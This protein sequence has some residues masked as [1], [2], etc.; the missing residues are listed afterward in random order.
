MSYTVRFCN[1]NDQWTRYFVVCVDKTWGSPGCQPWTGD[2]VYAGAAPRGECIASPSFTPTRVLMAITSSDGGYYY[3][4]EFVD[5]QGRVVRRCD[6]VDRNNP[7]YL[8]VRQPPPTPTPTPTP[9]P[10]T[11]TPTPPPPTPTPTPPP[12]PPPPPTPTPPPTQ[13]PP[14][15][16]PGSD[17]LIIA[18]LIALLVVLILAL[19][20]L[21]RK[22]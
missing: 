10:P 16:T 9:P 5:S 6:R 11:P 3:S 21:L 17:W 12:T 1:A 7:C 13:P 19:V 20:L 2:W 15:P 18:I 22:K 8:D 14:T 4:V